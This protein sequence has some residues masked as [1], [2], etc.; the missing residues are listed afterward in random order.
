MERYFTIKGI[1]YSYRDIRKDPKAYQE[2]RQRYHGDIVPLIVF[3]NGKRIVDGCDIPAIERT[4]R[5]LG[6]SP[7][8][9]P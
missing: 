9:S 4:L 8:S 3:G 7:P 6:V 5:D 2:W 1:P